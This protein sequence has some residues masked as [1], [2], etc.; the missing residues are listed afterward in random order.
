MKI[1]QLLLPGIQEH[2]SSTFPEMNPLTEDDALQEAQLLGVRFD[3]LTLT[4]GLLF[5]LRTA[6][7]LRE[8]NT[9]VLIAHGV[10]ALSWSGPRRSTGLTA[11]TIGGSTPRQQHGVLR[12]DL[13]MWPAPGAQLALSTESATF[14]AV[15]VAHLEAAPPDYGAS[16][17]GGICP[18]VAGWDSEFH[19]VHAVSWGVSPGQG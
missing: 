4:A 5:E 1:E 15:N 14:L 19:V 2:A 18:N 17:R 7:Q 6:M 3:A 9:G 12:L 16:D 8:A 11:W 13:G 10:T